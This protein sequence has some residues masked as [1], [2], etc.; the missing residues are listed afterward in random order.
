MTEHLILVGLRLSIVAVGGLLTLWSLRL[1]LKR[2]GA[3]ASYLLLTLGFG[4][5][6][7]G[8]LVEGLL[9][10]VAKWNLAS[11]HAV[12]ALVSGSGF[13]VILISIFRSNLF[14]LPA[15]N[16]PPPRVS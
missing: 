2:R 16:A 5:I 14:G 9:F 3:R 4:L 7:L 12:E 11:A 13:V 6:T 15:S 8:A 10:E 1:A